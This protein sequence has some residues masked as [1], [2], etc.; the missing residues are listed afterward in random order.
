FDGRGFFALPE[1]SLKPEK[2]RASS[3]FD[4]RHRAAG[5]VTWDVKHD[6]SIALTAEFQTGQPYT[7]NTVVDRN[8]DGNLTDRPG[9]GR[10]TFRAAEI[11]TIDAAITRRIPLRGRENLAARVEV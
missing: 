10:N 2:D 3:N 4:A 11:R 1:D 5:F 6:L 7:V 8:R 9:I